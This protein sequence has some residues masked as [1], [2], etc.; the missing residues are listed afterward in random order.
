M[1]GANSF[2]GPLVRL[3]AWWK[4]RL[5]TA[6]SVSDA[7]STLAMY[8]FKMQTPRP[9]SKQHWTCTTR[10]GTTPPRLDS[11]RVQSLHR[12]HYEPTTATTVAER[13]AAAFTE[14]S[15]AVW[16]GGGR[17]PKASDDSS[18]Q[19][20]QLFLAAVLDY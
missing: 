3:I 13:F 6:S 4:A 15:N 12:G 19:Q 1:A 18:S 7:R 10:R 17:G 9:S 16:L 14:P 20:H 5:L 11:R 8:A 2:S